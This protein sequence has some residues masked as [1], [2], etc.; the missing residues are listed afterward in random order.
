MVASVGVGVLLHP[1]RVS[2]TASCSLH[3]LDDPGLLRTCLLHFING[4]GPKLERQSSARKRVADDG[5][6]VV[7]PGHLAYL[8]L[9]VA[10][11]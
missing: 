11:E 10:R 6:V 1:R 2:R 4:G 7:S 3:L 9:I 5:P 8:S